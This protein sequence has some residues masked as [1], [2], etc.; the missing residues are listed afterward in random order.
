ML[1][2]C[3]M[4]SCLC[5][6]FSNIRFFDKIFRM[7]CCRLLF[8]Y[9]FVP[10]MKSKRYIYILFVFLIFAFGALFLIDDATLG[11]DC[12]SVPY[13]EDQLSSY[14]SDMVH[15]N[16]CMYHNNVR[17]KKSIRRNG[18][19]L[20][21]SFTVCRLTLETDHMVPFSFDYLQPHIDI[22]RNEVFCVY[23]I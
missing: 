22:V 4:L 15:K 1:H 23:R 5:F 21:L 11:D 7:Q 19:R 17:V 16:L 12:I 13:S 3:N 6:V 9:I 8:C 14:P 18:S 20:G 10:I 2:I